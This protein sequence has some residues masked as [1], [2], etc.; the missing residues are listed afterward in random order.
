M[1]RGPQGWCGTSDKTLGKLDKMWR[2]RK[3][4]FLLVFKVFRPINRIAF[5]C[6]L[7]AHISSCR[8]S[9]RHVFIPFRDSTRSWHWKNLLLLSHSLRI[10]NHDRKFSGFPRCR[11]SAFVT[12]VGVGSFDVSVRLFQIKNVHVWVNLKTFVPP[13]A[14]VCV[15]KRKMGKIWGKS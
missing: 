6:R 14:F 7:S 3:A 11:E 5:V 12:M 4:F 1:R 15:H 10:D 8:F 9:R 13:A 2:E